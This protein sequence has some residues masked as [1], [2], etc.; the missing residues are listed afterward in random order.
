MKASCHPRFI[1]KSKPMGQMNIKIIIKQE[2]KNNF[3]NQGNPSSF[4]HSIKMD[5]IHFLES[6]QILIQKNPKKKKIE[7]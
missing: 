5:E 7:T 2:R 3:S 4:Y 1:T 6:E